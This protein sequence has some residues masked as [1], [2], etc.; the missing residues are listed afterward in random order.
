MSIEIL[1]SATVFPGIQRRV[2]N[3]TFGS[4]EAGRGLAALL[5]VLFHADK[6]VTNPAYWHARAFGGLFACGHA[7]V[8]FF[9]VLSG[10]IIA[11]VHTRDIGRPAQLARY[12]TRR[13]DRIF[14]LYWLILT[15]LVAVALL[16]PDIASLRHVDTAAIVSSYLLVGRDSHAGVLTVSWT[17]FHELLFYLAFAALI[18]DRRA[19]IVVG[20]AWLTL[21][22]VAAMGGVGGIPAYV[23][24]P[25]NLL[26]AAGAL[27]QVAVR[28]RRVRHPL[29][30]TAA[31]IAAFAGLAAEEVFVPVLGETARNLLYG[32]ASAVALAGIVSYERDHRLRVPAIL[33]TLGAAS[34]SIYLVHYPALSV[35]ARL[36][37]RAGLI[38]ALP[39]DAGVVVLSA[40]VVAAGVGV[41]FAIERPLLAWRRGRSVGRREVPFP[42]LPTPSA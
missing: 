40:A 35:V 31:G 30:W 21:I 14:P 34:Y 27:A 33:S 36:M 39:V 25:L 7:G 42:G 23:T 15:V 9:F 11:H 29:W 13:F 3:R 8:E 18:V 28:D 10:F 26:F 1:S 32:V 38:A 20:A 5:V 16:G 19:G 4:I 24:S 12:V 37:R 6:V 2:P 41:H 22:A 17:L